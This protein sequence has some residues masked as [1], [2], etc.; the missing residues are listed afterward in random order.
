MSRQLTHSMR[1]FFCKGA[2]T[3]VSFF[4]HIIRFFTERHG[5]PSA[6]EV[7]WPKTRL[8]LGALHGARTVRI[9]RGWK[10][11]RQGSLIDKFFGN[12]DL[13]SGD[14]E[15]AGILCPAAHLHCH[16]ACKKSKGGGRTSIHCNVDPCSAEI[17]LETVVSVSL[18]RIQRAVSIGTSSNLRLTSSIRMNTPKNGAKFGDK[19]YKA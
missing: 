4:E 16:E 6:C 2:S 3:F 13:N 5:R 11:A 17:L 19:R 12:V 10:V 9:W 1:A 14:D 8:V 7:R 15:R 18:F